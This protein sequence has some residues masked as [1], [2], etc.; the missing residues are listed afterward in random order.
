M[1]AMNVLL[2][3]MVIVAVIFWLRALFNSS[4]EVKHMNSLMTQLVQTNQQ[5][6]VHLND[7]QKQIS[8]AGN[9]Q[10]SDAVIKKEIVAG[11][12]VKA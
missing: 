11:T 8:Q 6:A 1:D 12:E 7:L 2:L 9:S 5:I 10:V 3:I 4:K